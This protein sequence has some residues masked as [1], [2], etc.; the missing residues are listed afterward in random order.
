MGAGLSL[1][2]VFL[3]VLSIPVSVAEELGL[4]RG[5][6]AGWI[7]AVYG[8]PGVLT[9]ALVVRYRQPLLVTGNVFILIFVA[10]LGTELAWSELIGA[11][12]V[13][14]ALV[15]VIG[16]LGLTDRLATWLPAPIVYGLLAGAVLPF[17]IQLFTALG[18][19][20][21]MVGLT[22]AAYVVGHRVL[23]ARLAIL[24]ALVVGLA[25][26]G[27]AGELGGA[28]AA[29]PTPAFTVP[30]FSPRAILTA[31]PVMV[32]LITVQANVPSVVFLR[33]EEYRPPER[34]LA[35][36]SGVG[37]VGGSLLGPMG[38]SLSLPATALCAG[39]DAGEHDLRHR[40]AYV[41]GTASVVIALLAGFAAELATIVPRALLQAM[42][43]LAVLGVLSVA[44]GEVTR[45]PLRLGPLIAFA[46][47]LSDL[48][49]LGLG[50]FFWALALGLG[51]SLVMERDEWK[52]HREQ[53]PDRMRADDEDRRRHGL[54]FDR[55]ARDYEHGRPDYPDEIF[56]LLRERCG[57]GPGTRVLEIGPGTGQATLRLLEIGAHVT[58]VEPGPALAARLAERA[59]EA[60]LEVIVS[61][62]E[63][64]EPPEA[65]FD[66]VCSATAFH[67]VEP[68]VG[69]AR[70]ARTL[71]EGGW[72]ALWWTVF[73]DDDRPDPFRG[74]LQELLEVKAPHLVADERAPLHHALDVAT[75]SAEID[76]TG[77]FGPVEHGIFRWDGRHDV[78]GIRR[79]F[80]TVSPWMALD[81]D[82][83]AELLED[84][85]RLAAERFG[86]EVVRPYQTVIYTARRLPR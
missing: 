13:A 31:T 9:I 63:D 24:P 43:G 7:L 77:L 37:T 45:G 4:A 42:V 86:G 36:M 83:R 49:L 1:V 47:A 25:V 55:S 5:E 29:L 30:R 70:A 61:S 35:V 6:A 17:V 74:A 75:R 10:S 28:P 20:R 72:L 84:V 57:L 67:W 71:R 27:L 14:G 34:T 12:I 2:V 73:L 21:L 22:L 58:A 56:E 11:S 78:L 15:L 76:A 8:L 44:L 33:A 65:A 62:F 59:G 69:L 81:D 48:S 64:A 50:P 51:A 60:D 26:A 54:A 3:A 41:A 16:P 23:G 68:D 32:V 40:S 52:R 82:L 46:V 39:P 19:E 38:V 66:L 18:E 53:T 85:E 80:E 79:F